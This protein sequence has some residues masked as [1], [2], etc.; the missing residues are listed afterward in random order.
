MVWAMKMRFALALAVFADGLVVAQDSRAAW[1]W[2]TA[3]PASQGL[4]GPKLEAFQKDLAA[5]GTKALLLARNDKIVYEC[6]EARDYW[7]RGH[8]PKNSSR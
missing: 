8:S 2:T 5:R 3:T 1:D 7:Q 4:S 6:T